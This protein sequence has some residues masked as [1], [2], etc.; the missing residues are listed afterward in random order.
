MGE[1]DD[2]NDEALGRGLISGIKPPFDVVVRMMSYSDGTRYP[3]KAS[4]L[5]DGTGGVIWDK[6]RIVPALS[7]GVGWTGSH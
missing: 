2:G 6:T 7:C 1:V 4:Q 3:G 5:S